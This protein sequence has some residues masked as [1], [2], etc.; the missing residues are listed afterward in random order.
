MK[1]LKEIRR[2]LQNEKPF[3]I[4]KYGIKDIKIFGSFVRGEQNSKS[5]LDILIDL[6]KPVKMD[7]IGLIELENYLSDL[8]NIKVEISIKENL[9]QRIGKHILREAIEV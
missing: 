5:D 6:E 7:L 1:N 9:K 2:V 8:I 4:Q 3:L